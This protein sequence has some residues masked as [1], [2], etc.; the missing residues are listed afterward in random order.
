MIIASEIGIIRLSKIEN[1]L[2]LE[3]I[4]ERVQLTYFGT[5]KHRDYERLFQKV[6]K[7]LNAN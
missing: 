7:I 1:D 4:D 2:L 3:A 5:K 6:K